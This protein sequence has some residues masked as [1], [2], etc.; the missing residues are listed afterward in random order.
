[1]L[2][3]LRGE[4]YCHGPFLDYLE[5]R[6][7]ATTEAAM[8]NLERMVRNHH[9]NPDAAIESIRDEIELIM[10]E[11]ADAYC[12]ALSLPEQVTLTAL[13]NDPL[14][15][16]FAALEQQ[17]SANYQKIMP[18]RIQKVLKGASNAR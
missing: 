7:R 3:Q 17:F 2:S 16:R 11:Q 15:L 12:R 14:A 5:Q 4:A 9:P 13:L 10:V 8:Q 6:S 18:A 1:M